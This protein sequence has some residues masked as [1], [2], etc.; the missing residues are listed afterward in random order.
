VATHH[1]IIFEDKVILVFM[2]V[3][4]TAELEQKDA[5][6]VKDIQSI[7]QTAILECS[8]AQRRLAVGRGLG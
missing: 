4:R 1:A 5:A 8:W 2:L 3:F 6:G 7:F